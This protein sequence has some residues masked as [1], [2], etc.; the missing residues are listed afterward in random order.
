MTQEE[1]SPPSFVPDFT[2]VPVYN[3]NRFIPR[4]Q[5][6]KARPLLYRPVITETSFDFRKPLPNLGMHF[7]PIK[8]PKINPNN[9]KIL[10]IVNNQNNRIFTIDFSRKIGEG[11]FSIIYLGIF[12]PNNIEVAVKMP[13]EHSLYNYVSNEIKIYQ[14][15]NGL[16]GIPK[17]YWSGKYNN[18]DTIVFKY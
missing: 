2:P 14:K 3:H 13:R 9:A 7:S 5:L 16:N 10:K 12:H 1:F 6:I 8:S 4:P 17:I 11:F 15:L 18:K